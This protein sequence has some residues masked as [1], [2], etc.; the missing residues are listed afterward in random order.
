MKTQ[1]NLLQLPQLPVLQQLRI[2]EALLRADDSNWLILNHGSTEAIVMGISGKPEL[3]INTDKLSQ[4]PIP[5]IKRFSGG[6][7]VVVDH[8]TYFATWICN[9]DAVGVECCPCKIHR[10]TADIYSKALPQIGLKLEEN[11][12]VIGE[13]KCG[14]NAQYLRRGRWLHHTSFLWDYSPDLM[15]YLLMPQKTPL[16]RLGR[17]HQEFI[18]T[19][20][21]HV[22]SKEALTKSLLATVQDNFC[23]AEIAPDALQSLLDKPHRKTTT[24][25]EGILCTSLGS[26]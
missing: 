11:D 17:S 13:R 16:Y 19:L 9:T 7:T 25:C 1:L 21:E 26:S 5:I 24:I 12:Y 4:R 18:C 6:G 10:W 20:K 15:D 22:T 8:N 2:E 23:V 3:L 14:G